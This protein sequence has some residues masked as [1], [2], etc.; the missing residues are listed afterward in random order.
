M[1]AGRHGHDEQQR[2]TGLL[3]QHA[4]V[5]DERD[6]EGEDDEVGGALVGV[7][8]KEELQDGGLFGHRDA[9]LVE[10]QHVNAELEPSVP[11]LS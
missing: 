4:L 7:A 3:P 1:V 5:V 6:E 8:V 10:Q 9:E 11:G 2:I